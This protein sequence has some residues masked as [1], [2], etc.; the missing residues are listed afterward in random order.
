MASGRGS[1]SGPSHSPPST[2]PIP[3]HTVSAKPI[4]T[5]QETS[6]IAIPIGP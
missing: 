6:A 3:A 1:D 2:A 5:S 4:P